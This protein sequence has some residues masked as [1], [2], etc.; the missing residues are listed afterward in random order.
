ME[1][2]I[3]EFMSSGL[4]PGAYITLYAFISENL[5]LSYKITEVD[6]KDYAKELQYEGYIKIDEEGN[7]ILRQKSLDLKNKLVLPVDFEKFWDKYH[8]VI[9]EWPKTDKV[10]A[11]KYWKKLTSKEKV[12][13]YSNIQTYYDSAAVI[14]GRKVVKKARTYLSD[15]NFN[16]E[17]EQE[18]A[19]VRSND[20]MI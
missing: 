18:K 3:E 10:S 6:K 1:F 8:E 19:V 9:K 11:E 13:A 15:K 12:K 2:T 4:S 16:D 5:E 17:F 7:W 20:V 14:R